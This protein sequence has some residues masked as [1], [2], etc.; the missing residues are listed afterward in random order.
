[1]TVENAVAID[2]LVAS[3]E[4]AGAL[5]TTVGRLASLI[6]DGQADIK[7]IVEVISYDQALTATLLRRANSAAEGG[8]VQIKTVKDAAIRLGTSAL[9][10]MAMAATV[11]VRMKA[12]VPA[13]GLAEGELWRRSVAASIAADVIR[14]KAAADVPVEAST[15]ALLHDFGKV[16]ISRHFGPQ[17]FEMLATAADNEGMSV[18]E[19]E[20]AVL[21]VDHA[22]VGGLVAQ[23]WKL[24]LS[25]VVAILGHHVTAP[26][27]P[28]ICA[29]VSLAH[30]LLDDL[31]AADDEP[32]SELAA[33]HAGV[34]ADLGLE[35][36]GYDLLLADVRRRYET[37]SR[38]FEA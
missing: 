16:V 1:M 3:A 23:K 24:P 22:E 14:A 7:Q 9:L 36:G 25:I 4:G 12:P 29:A 19:A 6:A 34:F 10:S 18:L 31:F 26:A 13:Y 17:L 21:G 37:V 15:A 8:I 27:Q 32:R 11:S 30:G 33:T 28:P 38:R 20:R 2:E 5:A 35:P